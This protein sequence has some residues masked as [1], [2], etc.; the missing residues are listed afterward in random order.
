MLEGWGGYSHG[1]SCIWQY[2]YN[3]I[4]SQRNTES[5]LGAKC[6]GIWAPTVSLAWTHHAS[7]RPLLG[8]ALLFRWPAFSLPCSLPSLLLAAVVPSAEQSKVCHA[9]RAVLLAL[10]RK[11]QRW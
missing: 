2:T 5:A 10:R 4:Q 1:N 7:K 6:R 8:D 9:P 11:G 3:I